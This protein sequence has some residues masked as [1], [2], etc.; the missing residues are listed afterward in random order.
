MR[1][2]IGDAGADGDAV[3]IAS[4]N[5]D[6]VAHA[7]A[8]L[9]AGKPVLCE[10]PFAMNVAEAERII[11]ISQRRRILCME[12]VATPFLPAVSA[13]LHAAQAGRLGRLQR[14]EASFGYPVGRTTHPRL[15]EADGGV[16]ADRAVY[17]LMLAMIAMGMVTSAACQ[18]ERDAA[19]LDVGA[20]FILA[21]VGGGRSE[22]AV[23]F[24]ERLDNSLRIE[25]DIAVVEV[26]PPLLSARRLNF[27]GRRQPVSPLWRRLRQG[28]VIRRI[29]DASGRALGQWHPYGASPYSHEIEHFT[30]LVRAG[31]VES[32]V[33]SHERMLA[34]VRLVEQAR[35]A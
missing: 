27:S 12:A 18:V 22:L 16:L 21:H 6:H 1:A 25:G 32:P 20:R 24:V 33:I 2:L 29:G 3:Y 30:A 28:P 17:P 8:A 26:A 5:R 9:E 19:G 4:R 10:K 35:Q 14:L 34:V 13:A 31:A 11:A 15:F 23:S 7:I